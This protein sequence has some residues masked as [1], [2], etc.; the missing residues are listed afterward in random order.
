MEDFMKRCVWSENSEI[1]KKYH[2]EEW[3]VPSYDDRYLFE[4]INLEGQQSGLSWEIILKRREGYRRAFD[5]FNPL[6]ISNYDSSKVD[7]LM[8]N[9]EI[10]RH[11]KKIE[12]IINNA[13][14]YNQITKHQTFS[15]FL[16]SLVNHQK[17]INSIE[18]SSDVISFSDTSIA[19]SKEL[20]RLGFKFVGPTTVYAFMQAVGMVDDHENSCFKKGFL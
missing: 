17:L 1:M 20:K 2:D 10:I 16:W 5:N 14:V 13:K 8:Q 6:T 19:L 11:R 15:D 3:G 18:R 9:N 7:A 4:M 12:A